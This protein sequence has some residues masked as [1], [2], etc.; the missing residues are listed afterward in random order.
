MVR[1]QL[2][3]IGDDEGIDSVHPTLNIENSVH[4]SFHKEKTSSPIGPCVEGT[5]SGHINKSVMVELIK[6]FIHACSTWKM[7]ASVFMI[8]NSIKIT[9]DTPIVEVRTNDVG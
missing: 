6:K 1:S 8:S 9:H 3:D 2:C 7:A 4:H 5:L